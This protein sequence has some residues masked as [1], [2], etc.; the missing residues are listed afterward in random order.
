M[1]LQHA[2]NSATQHPYPQKKT[3]LF[4]PFMARNPVAVA[5]LC[6][7]CCCLR[8]ALNENEIIALLTMR[9]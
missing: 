6:L 7:C 1:L 9:L 5:F 2:K 4:I 8:F 3:F